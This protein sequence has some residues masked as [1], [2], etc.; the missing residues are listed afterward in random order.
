MILFV[1]G[2]DTDAGKTYA[3]AYLARML[4]SQGKSVATQKFI[5]TGCLGTSEDIEA[6]RRLCGIE[7]L[8]E[9]LDG[10]TAPI[11]F[12]YPASAQLAASIDGREIEL[13][14]IEQSTRRL[15]EAYDC[16]LIEGAGGLMVPV[17]DDY[18]TIDYVA[19]HQLPVVLVTNGRLGSINHTVLSLEAIAARGIKLEAVVYNS[20]FDKD[21]IICDD[22]KGFIRR[23]L[24]KHFPTARFIKM[25][26]AS[27]WKD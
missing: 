21:R 20:H 25:P 13:E 23:Y 8:P 4:A 24:A 3:T 19:A 16:V 17:T 15:E 1:S 6:H 18:F 22:T 12:S 2:I 26:D 14:K 7:A 10:T 27:E 5:Q 9:D 11:I